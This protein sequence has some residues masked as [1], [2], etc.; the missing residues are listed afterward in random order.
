CNRSAIAASTVNS[1]GGG[2]RRTRPAG[3]KKNRVLPTRQTDFYCT[4]A[5]PGIPRGAFKAFVFFQKPVGR[6]L[7][8]F[9]NGAMLAMS[10]ATSARCSALHDAGGENERR[11]SF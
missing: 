6:V 8:R 9:S 11:R 2:G 5:A 10:L 7:I 3:R 4:A 1:I